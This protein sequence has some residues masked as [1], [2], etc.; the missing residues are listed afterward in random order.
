[1]AT[2]ESDYLHQELDLRRSRLEE[3]IRSLG[4]EPRLVSL[5]EEVDA[6]LQR[7][8]R[9]GFGVCDVCHEPVE[10]ERL[11]RDPLL[12]TCLDHLTA[13][14]RR[15]LQEDLDLAAR[16]QTGLLPRRDLG[17]KGWEATFHYEPA[18]SVSGDYCDLI[19][20]GN[21][22]GEFT[23]LIGDV[24]GKGVAAS[25]MMAGLRATLRTL[26]GSG[27]PAAGLVERANALFCE[28][29]SAS[30]FAT[31]VCGRASASGTVE[32][33]N[34]GHCP[35]LLCRGREVTPLPATGLPIGLFCRSVYESRTIDLAPGDGIVIYTDGLSE[36]RNGSGDD[37][38]VGRLTRMVEAHRGDPP[39]S[40]VAACLEDLGA[41]R[42][43]SRPN[44]DLT[45]LAI[46]RS[47]MS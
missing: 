4:E 28:G 30:Q 7:M 27:L 5:L 17:I 44:D 38:G 10:A 41:F 47:S 29:I 46:R 42:G 14:E 18:G 23:F 33:C 25:M 22:S 35:P 32:I 6:A 11:L 16:I 19:P 45:L 37:Y 26:L 2:I 40:L 13:E 15:A 20:E 3:A 9:G 1:M 24:V 12:R 36:A 34:A 39:R 31:L 21:G 8:T 43:A